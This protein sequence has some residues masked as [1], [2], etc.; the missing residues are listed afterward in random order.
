MLLFLGDNFFYGNNLYRVVDDA[1]KNNKGATIFGYDVQDPERFG[2]IEYDKG[3]VKKLI[4][5]PKNPTSNQVATGLYIYKSDV[6]NLVKKA[7]L[8]GES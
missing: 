5:K 6:V 1:V 8:Q 3:Q 2:V 7:L 4:E